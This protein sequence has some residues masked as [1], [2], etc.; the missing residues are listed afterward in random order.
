MT[1]RTDGW[2]RGGVVAGAALA[3]AMAAVAMAVPTAGVAEA[4]GG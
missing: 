3:L 2:R 1:T 4:R